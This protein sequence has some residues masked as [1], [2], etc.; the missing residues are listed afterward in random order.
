MSAGSMTGSAELKCRLFRRIQSRSRR[1]LSAAAPCRRTLRHNKHN[2]SQQLTPSAKSRPH[3]RHRVWAGAAAFRFFANERRIQENGTGHVCHGRPVGCVFET[4]QDEFNHDS[5]LNLKLPITTRSP[6][7]I[8][9][10]TNLTVSRRPRLE[11][12]GRIELTADKPVPAWKKF[13]AQFKDVLVICGSLPRPSR[14]YCGRSTGIRDSSGGD[15]SHC[16]RF[17]FA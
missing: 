12:G 3:R 11:K 10:N 8:M 7:H 16:W 5:I 4:L 15:G 17:P 1:K 13:L 2:C 9:K 6:G 14:P